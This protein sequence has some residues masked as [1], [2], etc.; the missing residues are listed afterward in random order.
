MEKMESRGEW[1]HNCRSR[2]GKQTPGY[3]EIPYLPPKVTQFSARDD[4][5]KKQLQVAW[6]VFLK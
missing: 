3:L 1:K 2:C 4:D 5:K 6:N